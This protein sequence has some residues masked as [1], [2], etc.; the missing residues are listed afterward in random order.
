MAALMLDVAS[1]RG[2]PEARL[3]AGTGL[4]RSVLSDPLAEVGREQE[5]RMVLN[6]AGAMGDDCGVGLEI[7][8]R[9]QATTYGVLGLGI[10]SSLCARDVLRFAARYRSLC[11]SLA[12][13][14][15]DFG[16]ET[17]ATVFDDECVPVEARRI[18]F[19]REVSIVTQFFANATR[20]GLRPIRVACRMPAP[21]ADTV[22]R[23]ASRFGVQPEFGARVNEV[24]YS[25]R[26][27]GRPMRQASRHAVAAA[28][29]LCDELVLRRRVPVS[30]TSLVRAV[31]RGSADGRPSQV[32]VAAALGMSI[33]SLRQHLADEGTSFRDLLR[34]AGTERARTLLA[35]GATVEA[36]A[37]ELGYADPSAFSR[38]FVAWTGERPGAYAHAAHP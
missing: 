31:M 22:A 25:A 29:Q 21:P 10:L 20:E 32:E 1:E 35:R 26:D 27:L 17:G 8:R 18:L 11:F 19:E 12:D 38:A 15:I 30:T 24:V 9:A 28:E 33:R 2:V 3:L 6:L 14:S 36:V 16:R 23:Y 4:T 34:E 37:Q 5:L 13:L 7:G